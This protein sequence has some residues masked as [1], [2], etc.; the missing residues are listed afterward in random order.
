MCK[1][2]WASRKIT[3]P[4]KTRKFK[5]LHQVTQ[6]E[7]SILPIKDLLHPL[8]QSKLLNLSLSPS[9]SLPWWVHPLWTNLTRMGTKIAKRSSPAARL[10][11]NEGRFSRQVAPTKATKTKTK[12]GETTPTKT[13][14]SSIIV[15]LRRV[16]AKSSNR[17]SCLGL[18]P[19]KEHNKLLLLTRIVWVCWARNKTFLT[20][21]IP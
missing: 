3:R 5:S 13:R 20:A 12:R 16:A 19:G 7:V 15:W 8:Q 1:T 2:S 11:I 17:N 6:K 21:Q 18:A 14:W 10:T 4:K 9:L